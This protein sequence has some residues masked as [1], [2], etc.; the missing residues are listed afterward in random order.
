MKKV[1]LF[2][3]VGFFAVV[4]AACNSL[5]TLESIS[6][7]G[8]DV[9]FYVGEEFNTNDLV[10]TAKLS[11][12]STEVVTS[13][14]EVTHDVDTNKA[15]TYT[16]TVNYKGLVKTYTVT[17]L[18]NNLVTVTFEGLKT[19]YKIGEEVT[20]EGA[21]VKESYQS[22]LVVDADIA[23][24]E[25]VIKAGEKEYTGAFQQVGTNVVSVSK[26][27]FVY[28]YE[29]NVAANLYST[30]A[31]A[32]EAAKG[33]AG[34]VSNGT[35]SIDN[36]GYVVD[37]EFA[38][39]KGYTQ[40]INADGTSH[41]IE[42]ADGAVFGLVEGID[43]EGNPYV[44]PAY[45]PLPENLLGVDFRAVLNYNYDIFGVEGLVDTLAYVGVDAINYQEV[46]PTEVTESATYAFS[47]EII[48]EDFYY[49]FVNVEFV[50]D[51]NTEVITNVK[52]EMQGYM[53]I[54]NEETYEYE[55]P[56]EFVTPDFTR[57]VTASQVV[58]ERNAENPYPVEELFME[59]FDVTDFEG[60]KYENG[61][62]LTAPMKE[63][64]LL[65]IANVA[66][67][68]ANP[69][70]DQINVT[71]LDE[72]GEQTWS[73]FGSYDYGYVTLTAY[74]AGNYTLVISSAN[75]SYEFALVVDYAALESFNA[76][77]YDQDWY[78]LVEAST[79]TV[80]AG[81]VLQFGAL[82][83]SGANAACEVSCDGAEIFEGEY[84]E[85]TANEVGTYVI[86][87]TSTVNPEFTATL[88]VNVE[89]APS[90]AEIL[91]GKY[92]FNSA[93]LGTATYEFTPEAE[94]A[95][96]GQLVIVYEGPYVGSG[97]GHFTY[98]YTEGWL[99]VVPQ[100][101]ASYN[102]AFGVEM[103]ESFNLLCT[104]NYWAQG[105]LVKVE[106]VVEV[107]GALTGLYAATFVHPM[108][109]FEY[110]FQLTF[111]ADG[112]GSYSFM[113]NAYEGTFNYVNA[114]GVITFSEVVATF[115]AD[116]EITAT[117][118]DNVITCKTVFSDAGNEVELEYTGGSE[119]Q[120]EATTT[121]VVGE[122]TVF[123]SMRG[124]ELYFTPEESG[125][126][127]ITIDGEI[128]GIVIESA[129]EWYLAS[130]TLDLEANVPLLIVVVT[131]T[132]STPEQNAT[133]TITKN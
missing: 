112:T 15:G 32:I 107:E 109:N 100:N 14:A 27:E 68:T 77:V 21:N 34:K 66:P 53:F 33:N 51:A 105:N 56:T 104:Y 81:Q 97:E 93:M 129:D 5:P 25:V 114:E 30:I 102:C 95:V 46:L 76:A 133:L 63:D 29:V 110:L 31:D 60:N 113:N 40:V 11:D 1:F 13:A 90:V 73:V 99:S 6:I 132:W 115:G 120:K 122:N 87:L 91:N 72:F 48:I 2:L 24:Y 8:Q 119:V 80:Y 94:G 16:V 116:V 126:Y 128:A 38:F 35:A 67:E 28:E 4:V 86:T 130:Y 108:N 54:F 123:V 59:S 22:G 39:G 84:Y 69:S 23:T 20:F 17:V 55:Q 26:G 47:F 89:E 85:F 83:N 96:K 74:K 92:Q 65:V 131:A 71:V 75:V 121:P 45:E 79:A 36:D 58:G 98:E 103:D 124:T 3:L 49:Y 7:E 44:E 125:S 50:L 18:E 12:A 19:E 101:V 62:T 111:V 78:E 70:V 37:N 88:T 106:E 52:V 57:I 43:W 64:F 41:Y 9:E 82:V 10:V 127:T 61:A 42:L 118:V 117:I